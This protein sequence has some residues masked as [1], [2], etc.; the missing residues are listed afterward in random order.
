[1]KL[2]VWILQNLII[3]LSGEGALRKTIA[4]DKSDEPTLRRGVFFFF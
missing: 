1:M 2:G 4:K 3:S